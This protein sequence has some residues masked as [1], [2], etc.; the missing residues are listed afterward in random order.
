MRLLI[1][2]ILFTML[3]FHCSLLFATLDSA[4]ISN[5]KNNKIKAILFDTFGT[6]VD[7]RGSMK[8]E[9]DIIFQ[10]K[11]IRNIDL[12]AFVEAWVMAYSDNMS[13]ISEGKKKFETVDELNRQSLNK[14][15]KK[16]GIFNHFT[17]ND[18]NH[19]YWI[20]HRLTPWPDS[21]LGLNILRKK[22]II[23]AL[24]NGNVRLL[25]DLSKT[26]HL[27]WDVMLS[28]ELIGHYKPDP[29]V[30][31]SATRILQLTPEEILLVASHKFDLKAARKCGFKTAYIFRPQEFKHIHKNQKPIPKEFDYMI[32]NISELE[33]LLKP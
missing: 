30:Y 32:Q 17:L 1:K 16:Y 19:I 21:V 13:D 24:S 10:N 25:L 27:N 33:T 20:W 22:Y 4:S 6:L 11:K 15:L 28:G 29:L 14:T 26:G 2:K 31:Q 18:R 5:K 12:E 23:G 3:V 9:L 7:W 8:K